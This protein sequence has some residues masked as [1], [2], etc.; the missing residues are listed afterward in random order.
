MYSNASSMISRPASSK[1]SANPNP[2]VKGVYSNASS[3]I[4]RPASS[5]KSA[6]PNPA[7]KLRPT[8]ATHALHKKSPLATAVPRS[9]AANPK[10]STSTSGNGDRGG[11]KKRR[12][13]RRSPGGGSSSGPEVGS[14]AE[15]YADTIRAMRLEKAASPKL[16]AAEA[17]AAEAEMTGDA[18][19]GDLARAAVQAVREAVEVEASREAEAIL[20]EAARKT[21]EAELAAKASLAEAATAAS[22]L[23][24]LKK[25]RLE[26]EAKVAE[27]EQLLREEGKGRGE[28]TAKEPEAVP[29]TPAPPSTP[30]STVGPMPGTSARKGF[31]QSRAM[32]EIQAAMAREKARRA[33]ATL[34]VKPTAEAITD[35]GD[36][37][38]RE[39]PTTRGG[40]DPTNAA[41][42]ET[43]LGD[44]SA[45]EV[46]ASLDVRFAISAPPS[47][48]RDP[49]TM[50]VRA[51]RGVVPVP[52]PGAAPRHNGA[53]AA[54][55]AF[56]SAPS[57]PVEDIASVP[58]PSAPRVNPIGGSDGRSVGPLSS[59]ARC[60]GV[61]AKVPA[62]E[63]PRH[64]GAH[65]A[66]AAIAAASDDLRVE[67][68]TPTAAQRNVTFASPAKTPMDGASN[69]VRFGVGLDASAFFTPIARTPHTPIQE[70]SNECED[71]D[72]YGA[73]SVTTASGGVDAGE[74]ER[75]SLEE[76]LAEG[77]PISSCGSVGPDERSRRS[78]DS[79]QGMAEEAIRA[80]IGSCE[81]M[82]KKIGADASGVEPAAVAAEC[83]SAVKT[84]FPFRK[85]PF[86]GG[87][88][89]SEPAPV[90]AVLQMDWAEL[91]AKRSARNSLA[92]TPLASRP[93]SA[94]NSR[95]NSRPASPSRAGPQA[96][97]PAS[98]PNSRPAS[99]S[100]AMLA[101]AQQQQQQ[102]QQQGVGHPTPYADPRPSV[103]SLAQA[104]P[105]PADWGMAR[106]RRPSV[107]K[108]QTPAASRPASRAGS[109]A[110]SRH[111]SP[112][113]GDKV[114]DHE[115]A[116]KGHIGERYEF[117]HVLGRGGFSTV[118]AARLKDT[119]GA[120]KAVTG[121]WV[122]VKEMTWVS[123]TWRL[124]QGAAMKNQRNLTKDEVLK[125]CELWRRVC[126]PPN[127][128]VA[129]LHAC[130]V[131]QSRAFLVT[132]L[133]SGG[134]LMDVM[135]EKGRR[136]VPVP[137]ALAATKRLLS[138]LAHCHA[139]GI[140]H[141]DVKLDNLLLSESGDAGSAKLTDFGL[142]A[143]TG[144]DGSMWGAVCGTP[145]YMAPELVR[146]LTGPPGGGDAKGRARFTPAIDTWAAGV[147]LM[148][149]L[150]GGMPFDDPLAAQQAAQQRG[151]PLSDAFF[152]S[153]LER[154]LRIAS[155][156]VANAGNRGGRVGVVG[157][158]G[159]VTKHGE[160]V[161]P[162]EA[163]TSLLRDMLRIGHADRPAPEALVSH[164]ALRGAP[165]PP[166]PSGA[167]RPAAAQAA[168]QEASMRTPGMGMMPEGTRE[169][170][171]PT[172]MEGGGAGW[173]NGAQGEDGKSTVKKSTW[174]ARLFAGVFGGSGGK[175][176][177]A[178]GSPAK[179]T[180]GGRMSPSDS[181]DTGSPASGG[182]KPKWQKA[183]AAM[184]KTRRL[185][186]EWLNMEDDLLGD[187]K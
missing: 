123:D 182:R 114:E 59:S 39:E 52:P 185:Y 36:A 53:H 24:A 181:T 115:F 67:P 79:A 98:R 118:K 97:K 13:A 127:D 91:E 12:P 163:V 19:V 177:R 1:K 133:M 27:Q 29:K 149:M 124:R 46:K 147:C 96:V 88:L 184:A 120:A 17:R 22:K 31:T 45:D 25:A 187:N 82:A 170:V 72:G 100:R 103:E 50:V 131:E 26:A 37:K 84:T 47:P 74:Y 43:R 81:A 99:P 44:D 93:G 110:G 145:G 122:A 121:Q 148:N 8:S 158:T 70:V 101:I 68:N 9:T 169:L 129:H 161:P 174:G 3:M 33:A 141:R 75:H 21:M 126:D 159:G 35:E 80:A 156:A 111:G 41:K 20:S 42:Q 14:K 57:S 16:V 165:P 58:A 65:A 48:T 116:T 130:Y 66:A 38:P 164:P 90:P 94:A 102:Q 77:S 168:G 34:A 179:Y 183:A 107:S 73:A 78:M 180:V 2:V 128:A 40:S 157:F 69:A 95:P 51:N 56:A 7:V 162:P 167:E 139:R 10:P 153:R 83:S 54:A 55:A 61:V 106:R 112:T 136:G 89:V 138:A 135:I 60:V 171:S 152:S 134:S 28:E 11:P 113:R 150:C 166:P 155:A 176:N 151:R 186:R 119:G 125:E 154:C 104:T 5:K 86:G 172:A 4:S 109:R 64:N 117:G 6:N 32:R 23:E 71:S 140:L 63:P 105:T 143:R 18:A 142:S 132:D 146:A 87:K 49:E 178:K 108:P 137:A 160:W 144:E 15:A 76:D 85:V 92:P 173:G 175:G 62:G 30:A